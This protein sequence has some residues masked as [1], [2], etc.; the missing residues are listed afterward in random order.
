M[1]MSESTI[2]GKLLALGFT[3][4]DVD[5]DGNCFFASV[6]VVLNHRSFQGRVDWTQAELRELGV[7]YLREH[8]DMFPAIDEMEPYI[9]RMSGDG[10][11]WADGPIIAVGLVL[12][13]RM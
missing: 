9:G 2:N 1:R 7:N 11:W 13:V 8:P 4:E 6:A 5:G 3:R 12:Q 10:E